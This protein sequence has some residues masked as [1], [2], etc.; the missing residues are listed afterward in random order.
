M[1]PSPVHNQTLRDGNHQVKTLH[2]S[3]GGI[4]GGGELH[5]RN[6]VF[7][8]TIDGLFSFFNLRSGG[9]NDIN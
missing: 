4:G 3:T 7:M 5:F 6:S 8:L 9:M 1:I 2:A